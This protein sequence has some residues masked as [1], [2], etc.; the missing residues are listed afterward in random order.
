MDA[1]ED[2]WGICVFKTVFDKIEP[3]LPLGY[4]FLVEQDCEDYSKTSGCLP[5]SDGTH[6]DKW[7][8]VWRLQS[9]P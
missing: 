1:L 3:E 7:P 4:K 2:T 6:T 8:R 9:D 5:S